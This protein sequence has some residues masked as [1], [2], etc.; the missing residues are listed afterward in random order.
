MVRTK[1]KA[2]DHLGINR[3]TLRRGLATV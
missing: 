1:V 2:A 3:T